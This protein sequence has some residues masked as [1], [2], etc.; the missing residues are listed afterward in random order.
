[1]RRL[2][3]HKLVPSLQDAICRHAKLQSSKPWK[4]NAP[5]TLGVNVDAGHAVA[6]LES[7]RF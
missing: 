1:M 2:P 4:T 7:F 6:A 5:L 3:P